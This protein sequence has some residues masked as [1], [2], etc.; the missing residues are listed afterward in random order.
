MT[1]QLLGLLDASYMDDQGV[2]VRSVLGFEDVQYSIGIQRIC[3]KTVDRFRWNSNEFSILQ[4][5][6]SKRYVG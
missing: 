6:G 2:E 1:R 5:S 4:Q 3:G